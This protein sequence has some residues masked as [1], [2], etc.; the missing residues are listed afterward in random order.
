[1]EKEI[2]IFENKEKL[3]H[4]CEK[5]AEGVN[6]KINEELKNKLVISLYGS[7]NAGKSSTMNAL[8]GK[9]ISEVNP[10]PGWTKEIKLYP[11]SEDVYIADTPGLLDIN[12]DVSK[13][14][15]D[16]VQKDADLILFFICIDPGLI[17]PV[18]ESFK[19]ITD[20]K[21]EMLV[22]LTKIDYL[23]NQTDHLEDIKE[24]ITNQLNDYRIGTK[25]VPI[26][27]THNINIDLL[28]QEVLKILDEKGKDLLF[29]KMNRDKWP[30]V[31]HY[32]LNACAEIARHAV[33]N[34]Q[35]DLD[36]ITAI[37]LE[38]V[39]KIACVYDVPVT[40]ADLV[41]F[42]TD[43]CSRDVSFVLFKE[44]HKLIQPYITKIP[45]IDKGLK[46]ALPAAVTYGIGSAANSYY[47]SGTKKK[48][49]ELEKIF[50]EKVMEYSQADIDKLK[51]WIKTK[52]MEM[53]GMNI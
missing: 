18:F 25:L 33:W 47:S 37:Q 5:S 32:I 12:D 14:A 22:V 31:Q 11:Y 43:L 51:N 41:H 44:A 42:V 7:T 2:E 9:K 53:M 4:S 10:R 1:M 46:V 13:K 35:I 30:S 49:D 3:K 27:C 6:S 45:F 24:S 40:P 20:L 23:G 16:F 26:S 38:M 8:L 19:N 50:R 52:L 36:K 48:A 29:A 17:N 15:E 39:K 34:N 21:K 28:Q